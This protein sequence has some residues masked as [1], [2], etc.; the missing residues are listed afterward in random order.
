MFDP[1]RNSSSSRLTSET[2]GLWISFRITPAGRSLGVIPG[3]AL[4]G[5]AFLG[6]ALLGLAGCG[7]PEGSASNP[8]TGETPVSQ[9]GPATLPDPTA[10]QAPVNLSLGQTL[11]VP[12]YSHIHLKTQERT[13][14]LAA[15]VSIRNT[16]RDDAIVLSTI[17]YIDNSGEL[18]RRYLDQPRRLDP[19]AST[20]V[21]IEETDAAGGLGANFI[22]EWSAPQA[23]TAP[24]VESIMITTRSSLGISFTSPARVL[25]ERSVDERKE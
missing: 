19:L 11:Y 25:S 12:I 2:R 1:M 22:V 7:D 4:L 16:D 13:F 15:T 10:T 21:V 14:N 6:L 9:L 23:V 5:F 24:V 8:F 18:V 17:D 3:R 20:S